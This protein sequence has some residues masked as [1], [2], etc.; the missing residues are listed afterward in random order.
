VVAGDV[1]KRI[2]GLDTLRAVAIALVFMFHYMVFTSHEPTFGWLSEVGW[3]G[4]DLFFVLSGYLISNQLFAG[5]AKGRRLS[6]GAF[7]GRRLLRT[8]PNYYVVLAFYV[9]FPAVGGG[10][11]L[12]AVW[13]F[14]TFTQNFELKAGTA[15]SHAWSLCIEEQ[16]YLVLPVVIVLVAAARRSLR[17]AWVLVGLVIAAGIVTRSVLWLEYGGLAPGYMPK[18][19]YS[20]FCRFDEFLPGVAVA[21]VKNF[22]PGVWA[23]LVA[24]GRLMLG[25]GVALFVV[26]VALLLTTYE[27]DDG[28]GYF[29]TGF[30][31]SLLA[32]D[33]ALLV[34]A[35]L[36]PSS[37]LWRT[38][39]PGARQLALWSY[40]IYLTHKPVAELVAPALEAQGVS[41]KSWLAVGVITAAS[42][43]AGW[44][45]FRLVETPFMRLRER[46][47]ADSFQPGA[48]EE[49]A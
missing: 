7:Y 26:L 49:P 48:L 47:R 9:L 2:D 38:R 27:S 23:R 11:T 20:S 37:L 34:I 22:H 25:L 30:G 43:A 24:R 44:L 3:I 33:F 6:L 10:R 39:V 36:S 35:A 16:F 4:V 5:L 15:F 21:L 31:Y 18:I 46:F 29:M 12:P 19:Y 41:A 13:K 8:L 42:I 28:H 45:L 32:I 14:L 40:A 17:L 1:T